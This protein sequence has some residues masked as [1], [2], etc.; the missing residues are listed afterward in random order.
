MLLLG[1]KKDIETPETPK[2][3]KCALPVRGRS[4]SV[5]VSK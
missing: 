1:L 3:N 5:T 2:N 4:K